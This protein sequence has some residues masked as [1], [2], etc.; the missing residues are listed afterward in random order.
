MGRKIIIDE[1]KEQE[2]I[3]KIFESV[4]TPNPQQVIEVK[5]FLDKNFRKEKIPT[6]GENGYS[7]LQDIFIYHKNGVDL[8]TMKREEV[9]RMLDDKFHK[10]IT[11]DD[12]RKRFLEQVLDDW[13]HHRIKNGLLSV[14]KI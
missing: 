4:F 11:D 14:N 3:G 9:I 6:I 13:C 7:E 10:R 12:D 2:L 8:Q 1:A 5:E